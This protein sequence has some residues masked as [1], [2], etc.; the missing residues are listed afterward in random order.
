MQRIM[1]TERTALFNIENIIKW[2]ETVG[3]NVSAVGDLVGSLDDVQYYKLFLLTLYQKEP[4]YTNKQ[5][6][7]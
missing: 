3:A 7:Q 1:A 6:W 2:G 5:S 4:S